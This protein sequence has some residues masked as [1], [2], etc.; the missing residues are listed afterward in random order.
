MQEAGFAVV[1]RIRPLNNRE[2]DSSDDPVLVP[3]DGRTLCFDPKKPGK[4]ERFLMGKE[5]RKSWYARFDRLFDSTHTQQ[6]VY[7]HTAR[8]VLDDTLNGYNATVF[9]YGATG[10]GK[11]YSMVGTRE[12]PG[13]MVRSVNELFKR[14]HRR[15]HIKY[16]LSIS[17]LEIYNE[18]IRDLLT[19]S[20]KTKK[21][22]L[23]QTK[24]GVVVANLSFRVPRLASEVLQW[25]EEG[26]KL[27][28][29]CRTDMNDES[30]RSHAV[31]QINV[32]GRDPSNDSETFSKLSLIDLA[33]SERGQKGQ[34]SQKIA[35]EGSNI[36]RSLLALG[37]CITALVKNANSSRKHHIP[38]RDSKLTLLLKDSL[39]GNCRS[40]MIAAV[41][42]SRLSYEDTYNTLKYADCFKQIKVKMKSNRRSIP[43]DLRNY[44]KTLKQ[45]N[46]IIAQLKAEIEKLRGGTED[47]SKVRMSIERDL[48]PEFNRKATLEEQL[49]SSRMKQVRVQFKMSPN[50]GSP[51]YPR[52]LESDLKKCKRRIEDSLNQKGQNLSA[53]HQALLKRHAEKLAK[54]SEN[55]LLRAKI[56]RM[57][58]DL[59]RINSHI[60]NLPPSEEAFK[61]K[62]STNVVLKQYEDKP[63]PRIPI[64]II[65]P[66]NQP[67]HKP[68]LQKNTWQ[69]VF[70]P[71]Q[72][73]Q[74]RHFTPRPETPSS[75]VSINNENLQKSRKRKR[76]D[77]LLQ[78]SKK[79]F[80][81]SQR[82]SWVRKSGRLRRV[83][84]ISNKMSFPEQAPKLISW[85]PRSVNRA[86]EFSS[87]SNDFEVELPPVIDIPM[88]QERGTLLSQNF[89]KSSSKSSPH[90]A[91]TNFNPFIQESKP[92]PPDVFELSKP[93]LPPKMNVARAFLSRNWKP[94]LSRPQSFKQPNL[95]TP[96]PPELK[97]KSL[98]SPKG[99][100]KF[101][102]SFS[103]L[104]D[105]QRGL[106]TTTPG[107]LPRNEILR[108]QHSTT[109][110][111]WVQQPV[112]KP[113]VLSVG[114]VKPE[115]LKP[116]SWMADLI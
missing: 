20:K 26:N 94:P 95:F 53:L 6:D 79:A 81:E 51:D 64:K 12:E 111:T 85:M 30:S 83:D 72:Q 74:V 14:I 43:Q 77:D 4:R 10:S 11:T 103:Q 7:E 86:L 114:S 105:L 73:R 98:M 34:R 47:E 82:K 63:Q 3:I 17:Y 16:S 88:D 60:Q 75:N 9:A 44:K 46:D 15:K 35:K 36:N 40:V 39:G 31:L 84:L 50:G 67:S 93:T 62:H 27:R 37:N 91:N 69:P 58:R 45:K 19:M 106:D 61:L 1:V 2:K 49:L 32:R 33:G 110:Q 22:S 56:Q 100:N 115:R 102:T 25:L 48:I 59:I 68:V 57:E 109:T 87:Q 5:R 96:N 8:Q 108:I 90:Q 116:R 104:Q 70:N 38:F 76:V 54:D 80:T 28:S 42:P 92:N 23:R 89:P 101:E 65:E 41:S 52:R 112:K 107:R 29:K 18:E 71:P 66:I 21:L 78:S 55:K 24:Q 99:W 97:T 13:V 113:V